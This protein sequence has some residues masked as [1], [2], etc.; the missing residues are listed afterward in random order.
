MELAAAILRWTVYTLLLM[1]L[2]LLQ[3]AKQDS[4]ILAQACGK[5]WKEIAEHLP[6]L[7]HNV[8]G[9]GTEIDPLTAIG[10]VAAGLSQLRC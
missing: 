6:N 2:F 8:S 10:A 5:G 4:T 9:V 3:G 7:G 1:L